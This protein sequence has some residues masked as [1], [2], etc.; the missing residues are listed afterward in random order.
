MNRSFLVASAIAVLSLSVVS[1]VV[2]AGNWGHWRGEDGNGVATDANPPVKFG[3]DE[4]VR[5]K[6]DLPGKG[7]G[8]PVVWDDRVFVTS[9]V[10]LSS[11]PLGMHEFLVMAFD[12][13]TGQT[14]WSQV[15]V[16]ARPHEGTHSTNGFASASP[17]TDGRH[18]YASFNSR[19][20]F[21]YTMDGQLV[22]K[23]D[24]GDMAMRNGFGE[25][26][27][28]TIE[29]DMLLVPWDHEG[30]SS[31]YAL[32]KNTGD[33]IW[34][35]DRDE[36]SNWGTP[37]VIES[38][39]RSQ[40][41]LTG[42][43]K[44]R[45]YDLQTG[46]ELWSCGGQTERPA[47]SPVATDD[48]V[49]VTSG[50]RGA[51]LGAFDPRGRGDIEGTSSVV[52]TRHRDTPDI[53]SPLLSGNR[54]YFY[55]GKSGAL[56][57]VDVS[58]GRE[59]YVAQRISGLRTIYASPVAAGGHVYLSD[60][61]GSIVVIKDS[62]ELQIVSVNQMGETVDATPAPVDDQLIVRGEDHLFCLQRSE[63]G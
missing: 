18:V 42:Q 62:P 55:K 36:P 2:W 60:R 47:A 17:C 10:A 41:V 8:S 26:S 31:L 58:T 29:G 53:G 23:R 16:K 15:A 30:A 7:S 61:S 46:Q 13:N 57:C 48:L 35:T 3:A 6:V 14:L 32:D 27:S 33:I 38:E 12:R 40:V 63:E 54:L 22:W 34:K 21:C 19:G 45:S 56:T 25:G 50:F 9:A 1:P 44:V 5:W 28:P 59:H 37:L 43:N 24:L 20:L 39:G 51:F 52:W 11:D 4:N 49:I